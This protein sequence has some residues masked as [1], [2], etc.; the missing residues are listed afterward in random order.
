M[1]AAPFCIPM[2]GHVVIWPDLSPLWVLDRATGK[3]MNAT[4]AEWAGNR[5]TGQNRRLP[6]DH[7]QFLFAFAM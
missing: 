3:G 2:A 5:N 7:T 1:G 6:L 4:V